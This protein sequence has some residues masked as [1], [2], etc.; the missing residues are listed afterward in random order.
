TVTEHSGIFYNLENYIR[1]FTRAGDGILT[2]KDKSYDRQIKDL[3]DQVERMEQRL[4]LRQERLVAQFGALE[5][6]LATMQSQGNWLSA[7]LV[8][9]NNMVSQPRNSN[10]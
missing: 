3:K 9:L 8:Q 10:R 6:A 1:N 7:Q 5:I 2:E 4:E